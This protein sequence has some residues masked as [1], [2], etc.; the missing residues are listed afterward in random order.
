M[1]EFRYKE[2]K[3]FLLNIGT[4][5]HNTT[6][7]SLSYLSSKKHSCHPVGGKNWLRWITVVYPVGFFIAACDT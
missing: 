6:T 5:T 7:L 1:A 2:Q 3:L 4:H